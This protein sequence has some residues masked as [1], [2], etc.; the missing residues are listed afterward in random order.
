ME[1]LTWWQVCDGTNAPAPC[2]GCP[3]LDGCDIDGSLGAIG[4]ASSHTH[5]VP[6]TST[7]SSHNH[8]GSKSATSGGPSSAVTTTAGTGSTAAS[9]GH[10]HSL[11]IA[12]DYAGSHSHTIADTGSSSNLP[13]YVKRVFIQK[14]T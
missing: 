3:H 1:S 14:T 12:I 9:S 2:R 6:N 10:T 8:G 13:P 11:N 7:R 4:G 5:T